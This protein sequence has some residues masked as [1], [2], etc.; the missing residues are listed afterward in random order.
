MS[1]TI[2]QRETEA[3]LAMFRGESGDETIT[4]IDGDENSHSGPGLY[5]Y[6]SEY[7]D[8]GSIFLSN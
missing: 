7:P 2:N 5:A 1:I 3:L 8:E 6:D 4:V